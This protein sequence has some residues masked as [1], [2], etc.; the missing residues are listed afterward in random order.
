MMKLG[1]SSLVCPEWDLETIV[2][3][4]SAMGFDGV[5]LHGLGGE[6]HLPLVP[7][8]ADRPDSVRRMFQEKNLE[9][10]CLGTSAMLGSYWLPEVTRHKAAITEC[11]ELAAKLG[12]PYVRFG[13]GDMQRWDLHGVALSR[14]AEVLTSL[15]PVA[16]RHNVT[17]LVENGGDFPGSQELWFLVDAVGHPAV[18]C[19]WN[20]C[21]AIIVRERPTHSIPRLSSKI[22]LVHLCDATFDDQGV[23]LDYKPLGEGHAEIGRQIE[24]L[25][26]VVYDRYL[27]FEWPKM[28]VESL[29]A[30]EVVLPEVAKYLRERVDEKQ[31]VLSAYKGDKRAP[32]M[33]SRTVAPGPL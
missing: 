3:N 1:F 10:V 27:V 28:S 2:N 29:P 30:P 20:Q 11:I 12:C 4:A 26:G 25:K 16:T 18:R 31:P 8:L 19:C 13:L 17:L 24:L 14:I 7:E 21:S 22:D 33:A 6:L 15:V 5:E 32:K 9:L 23:L